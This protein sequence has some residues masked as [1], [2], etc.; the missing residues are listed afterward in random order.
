M[1]FIYKW[2]D[3]KPLYIYIYIYIKE[4]L[5]YHKSAHPFKNSERMSVSVKS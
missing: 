1:Q 3:L 4:Y 5:H 2:L